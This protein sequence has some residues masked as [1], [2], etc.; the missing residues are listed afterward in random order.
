MVGLEK[1]GVAF[2]Y[3]LEESLVALLPHCKHLLRHFNLFKN[4]HH[5]IRDTVFYGGHQAQR[6]Y[7]SQLINDTLKMLED[8]GGVEAWRVI[9]FFVPT[10]ALARGEVSRLEDLPLCAGTVLGRGMSKHGAQQQTG[11]GSSSSTSSS[12]S[13]QTSA[14]EFGSDP[15]TGAASR[16][17]RRK[18]RGSSGPSLSSPCIGPMGAGSI[19][20]DEGSLGSL[21]GWT[22]AELRRYSAPRVHGAL[23]IA[24]AEG[25][26]TE[27][28]R[29]GLWDV[30]QVLDSLLLAGES[31]RARIGRCELLVPGGRDPSS[32]ASSMMG[33]VPG[34]TVASMGRKFPALEFPVE[35]PL[36][37]IRQLATRNLSD[38]SCVIELVPKVARGYRLQFYIPNAGGGYR[39]QSWQLSSLIRQ[40]ALEAT[41]I[42]DVFAT[43]HAMKDALKSTR[44]EERASLTFR[45]DALVEYERMGV[46][47]Y[48]KALTV[49]ETINGRFQLCSTYPPV[50]VLPRKFGIPEI[51]HAAKHRS[52]NRLPI[53]SWL[54]PRQR[55]PGKFAPQ[56]PAA[57]WRSSQPKSAFNNRSPYD[58]R[59]LQEIADISDNVSECPRSRSTSPEPYDDRG[60][61]SADSGPDRRPLLILDARPK[62]NAYAN[63]MQGHGSESSSY[64]TMAEI[65]FGDVH[66]IK[67]VRDSHEAMRL[68]V[69]QHCLSN[70]GSDDLDRYGWQSKWSE[71]IQTLLHASLLVVK[72]LMDD[73]PVLVHCSDGWDRTSQIVCLA[74]LIMDPFYRTTIG[75]SHLIQKARA[76]GSCPWHRFHT[77]QANGHSPTDQYSPIF[78][79]FLHCV[80]QLM[81]QL[82]GAFEF[83]EQ[84]LLFLIDCSYDLRFGTFLYDS[85]MER[86]HHNVEGRTLGLWDWLDCPLNRARFKN[87]TYDKCNE[88]P[89]SAIALV[90]SPLWFDNNSG[91]VAACSRVG[92]QA[93]DV[94]GIT[95]SEVKSITVTQSS[96]PI[97]VTTCEEMLSEEG[98]HPTSSLVIIDEPAA[99]TGGDAAAALGACLDE[100]LA[101][102]GASVLLLS[103]ALP[104]RRLLRQF[105]D[106]AVVISP[107]KVK[108]RE[109]CS[110]FI[111]VLDEPDMDDLS[112]EFE[113]W[114]RDSCLTRLHDRVLVICDL[115][116]FRPPRDDAVTLMRSDELVGAIG[117]REKYDH[118]VVFGTKPCAARVADFLV[119]KNSSSRDGG[120]FTVVVVR[121]EDRQVVKEH[122][123]KYWRCLAEC[124]ESEGWPVKEEMPRAGVEPGCLDRKDVAFTSRAGERTMS[125]VGLF[126]GHISLEPMASSPFVDGIIKR[127]A[128]VLN[129]EQISDIRSVLERIERG[130]LDD[131]FTESLSDL[132]EKRLMEMVSEKRANQESDGV[133]DNVDDIDTL[134]QNPK[135]VFPFLNQLLAEYQRG[136]WPKKA[137][138]LTVNMGTIVSGVTASQRAEKEA[139]LLAQ[140]KGGGISAGVAE[141]SAVPI[142]GRFWKC[143]NC[144]VRNPASAVICTGCGKEQAAVRCEKNSKDIEALINSKPVSMVD[145]DTGVG[146]LMVSESPDKGWWCESCNKAVMSVECTGCGSTINNRIKNGRRPRLKPGQWEC[147]GSDCGYINYKQHTVCRKCGRHRQIEEDDTWP[148]KRQVP[149]AAHRLHLRVFVYT[150]LVEVFD[151]LDPL[152]DAPQ[153]EFDF[154]AGRLKTEALKAFMSRGLRG[155]QDCDPLCGYY[156][157]D[158]P[159]ENDEGSDTPR[160]IE[161]DPSAQVAAESSDNDAKER[162]AQLRDMGISQSDIDKVFAHYRPKVPTVEEALNLIFQ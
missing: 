112:H 47:K 135:F 157:T 87:G 90:P 33:L 155:L 109:M 101:V 17:A 66:N 21:D 140:S 124:R 159:S 106:A 60:S 27:V 156:Y 6:A 36:G 65:V 117:R 108:E 88:H 103:S 142:R 141:P 125:Y 19:C 71:L 16:V 37:H 54:S 122:N 149:D 81:A 138:S 148:D 32:A 40:L 70:P 80:W 23:P 41:R 139:E 115:D 68:L 56:C 31:F 119:T 7:L 91:I 64:Y 24:Q 73:R 136:N 162:L 102:D 98:S 86:V 137:T 59:L 58:E 114:L 154:A 127:V 51:I 5:R 25:D 26:P 2:L 43:S 130:R 146:S 104:S 45:Y 62:I 18:P 30:D 63:M 72:T 145:N 95:I 97:L 13:L 38:R 79:Q 129:E 77:R 123:E 29:E 53:L 113:L 61:S 121:E 22:V 144:A 111:N 20:S 94:K 1:V 74:M 92:W 39:D 131:K 76:L 150:K 116:N 120:D 35:V 151:P 55:K 28:D 44:S 93:L 161:D 4:H 14:V 132:V 158:D 84:F 89:L 46:S 96:L 160:G 11:S 105:R 42:D 134:S 133:G 147:W 110:F 12:S 15:L 75:F 85:E 3:H 48:P 143:D 83:N 126:C 50:I 78:L 69:M 57:L 52:K 153:K 128:G 100:L 67:H 49:H 118:A 107:S 10:V 82:P 8:A 34:G 99:F 9:K 152:L